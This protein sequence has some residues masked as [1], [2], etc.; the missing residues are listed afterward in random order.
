MTSWP[1]DVAALAEELAP[2]LARELAPRRPLLSVREAAELLNVHERTVRE[3]IGGPEPVLRSLRIGGSRKIDPADL[4][5]YIAE[6][7]EQAAP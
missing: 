5:A 2:R 4:D 1:V 7:K 3:M 6:R